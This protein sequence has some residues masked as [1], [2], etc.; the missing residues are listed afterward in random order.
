MTLCSFSFFIPLL[1]V[2]RTAAPSASWAMGYRALPTWGVEKEG[3]HTSLAGLLLDFVSP[4][5]NAW[6]DEEPDNN[7]LARDRLGYSKRVVSL[8]EG[9]ESRG[10][11]VQKSNW[12]TCTWHCVKNCKQLELAMYR[13]QNSAID[14][15]LMRFVGSCIYISWGKTKEK[16]FHSLQE[17]KICWGLQKT[18]NPCQYKIY[19]P[20][21]YTLYY[22][23]CTRC[24]AVYIYWWIICTDLPWC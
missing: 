5:Q 14:R 12:G 18:R 9:E 20:V 8:E 4:L 19:N 23:A 17:E 13:K 22:I 7:F 3:Q 24:V 11:D 2:P 16:T 15:K 21:L 6:F 1:P 10:W